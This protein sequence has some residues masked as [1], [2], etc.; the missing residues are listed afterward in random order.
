MEAQKIL[1]RLNGWNRSSEMIP[2]DEIPVSL[3]QEGIGCDCRGCD[4]D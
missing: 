4:K 3:S 1:E 2:E